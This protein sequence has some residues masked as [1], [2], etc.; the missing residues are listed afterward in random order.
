MKIA[1]ILSICALIGLAPFRVC[2]AAEPMIAA[3]Y[4]H[5]LALAPDGTILAWGDNGYGQLG[6]WT[7]ID[8]ESPV[9]IPGFG[10][11]EMIAVGYG[12]SVALKSD[13]TA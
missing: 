7:K 6:D 13:G 8:R 4:E 9:R 10:D 1:C 2:S 11:V 12:H 5:T 3:G